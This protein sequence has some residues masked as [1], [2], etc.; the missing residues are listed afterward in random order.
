[1]LCGV[2]VGGCFV[3]GVVCL[4]GDGWMCVGECVCEF[5]YVCEV[6]CFVE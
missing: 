1:M 5:E 4:V 2:V 3:V 6:Y